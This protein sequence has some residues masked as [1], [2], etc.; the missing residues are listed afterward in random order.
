MAKGL[1]FLPHEKNE[2]ADTKRIENIFPEKAT[3]S[4]MGSAYGILT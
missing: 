4:S 2:C 3:C 1:T